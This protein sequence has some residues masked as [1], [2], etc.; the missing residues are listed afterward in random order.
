MIEM[1]HDE[2]DDGEFIVIQSNENGSY[3]LLFSMDCNG[4]LPYWQGSQYE[5][6]MVIGVDEL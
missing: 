3:R 5:D 4:I 2:D 1:I 6:S